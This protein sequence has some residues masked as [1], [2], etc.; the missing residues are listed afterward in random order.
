MSLIPIGSLQVEQV[1]TAE[2]RVPQ[3]LC[4]RSVR[5]VPFATHFSAHFSIDK[6]T[7]YRSRPCSVRRYSSHPACDGDGFF[8]RTPNATNRSR[9]FVRIF[10][11]I[12]RCYSKMPNSCLQSKT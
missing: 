4:R 2:N 7:E 6:G 11:A 12:H 8:T 10:G 5:E 9:R 1:R 3:T